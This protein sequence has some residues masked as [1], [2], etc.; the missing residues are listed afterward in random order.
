MRYF[1]TVCDAAY[2]PRLKVL[3][4]SMLR[5]CGEFLLLVIPWDDVVRE[6]CNRAESRVR[7]WNR[8]DVETWQTEPLPGPERSSVERMWFA[9]AQAAAEMTRTAPVVMLDADVA[10]FADPSPMLDA[11]DMLAAPGAVMPHYFASSADDLP[12]LTEETHGVYGR[13]NAGV[14]YVRSPELAWRRADQTRAWCFNRLEDGRYADQT[15]LDDW[16]L[17]GAVEFPPH[18]AP[19]PWCANRWDLD[20]LPGGGFTFGGQRLV[21]WHFSS[22]K[23]ADDGAVI[24]LANPEYALPSNARMVY[25]PY[26]RELRRAMGLQDYAT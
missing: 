22:L 20:T 9:R 3:H 1:L 17:L 15:I 11:I 5:H 21:A 16:P 4:A 10:F 6:W 13:V 8:R 19:G 25:E 26:I 18:F 12:G 2:L 14:L 23:L 24:Q 7:A